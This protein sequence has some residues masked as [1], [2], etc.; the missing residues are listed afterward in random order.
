MPM[1]AS[2][3][4]SAS[5]PSPVYTHLTR[6]LTEKFEVAPGDVRPDAT[7]EDLDLDSLASVELFLALSEHYSIVL[8]DGEAVPELTVAQTAE[9]VEK[10]LADE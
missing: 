8:D 2:S 6:L 10:V 4:P 7:L 3:T 5:S 9:L 1:P